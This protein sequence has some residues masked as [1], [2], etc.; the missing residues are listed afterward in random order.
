MADLTKAT[1]SSLLKSVV[2]EKEKEERERGGE[3]SES[4]L[5]LPLPPSASASMQRSLSRPQ[6]DVSGAEIQGSSEDRNPTI[7]LP[8]Q[9]DDISHLAVDIGGSL[10]KLVYFS[11]HAEPPMGVEGCRT[12]CRSK[13]NERIASRRRYPILGGRLHFVKFETSKLNDC[14]NFIKSKKL[15]NGQNLH[16]WTIKE[17]NNGDPII[18]ATGGGAFKFTDIFKERLGVTLDKEDEMDCL[19]AGANFLLKAIRHEAFTHMEGHKEFSQID[20]NE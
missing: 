18:K 15:H 5:P 1:S 8:N 7:L 11:R 13:D 17:S 3:S 10:I 14:L 16:H 4:P 6:L 20:Q 19:V 12:K 9:S 2:E